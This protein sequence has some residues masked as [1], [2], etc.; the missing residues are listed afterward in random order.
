LHLDLLPS[1]LTLGVLEAGLYGLLPVAVVLTYRIS[2]TIGFVHGGFAILGGLLYAVLVNGPNHDDGFGVHPLMSKWAAFAL[3]VGVG[4]LGAAIYG[5]LVMSRW[6]AELPGL[7]LTVI[8]IA[9]LLVVGNLSGFYLNPGGFSIAGSPFGGGGT[10][11]GG[12]V[13]THHRLATLL[14]LI[15]VVAAMTVF[16]NRTYT[17]LAIRAIADDVEASVWCGAKLRLIGTGVYAVSGAIAAMAGAL[18]A[19]AVAEAADGMLGLFVTGL[20]LAIVGGMRSV[21]LAL[22]AALLYGVLRTALVAGM[23][24]TVRAGWQQVDLFGALIALIIIAARFRKESFFLLAGH[25][26]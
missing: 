21:P 26:T 23:F 5:T 6:M 1:V 3:V 10:R 22:A 12:V 2:R 11:F 16:L 8:S 4:A 24:G 18:Y 20:L 7:T 25:Q 15:A 17:G 13:V 19:G 9:G 14:I